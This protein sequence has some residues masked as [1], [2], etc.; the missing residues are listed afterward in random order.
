[1]FDV[2]R[3]ND[4]SFA[5]ETNG[6]LI[7]NVINEFLFHLV[8]VELL[9]LVEHLKFNKIKEFEAVKQTTN[10]EISS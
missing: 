3:S 6:N 9:E 2:Y 1:M 4:D 10:E 8:K 7:V 5:V